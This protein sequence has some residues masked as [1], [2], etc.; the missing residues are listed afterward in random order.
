MEWTHAGHVALIDFGPEEPQRLR[1]NLTGE[2]AVLEGRWSLDF[3][4]PLA[5]LSPVPDDDEVEPRW[6]NSVLAR[7]VQ[8]PGD[9]ED[10]G[11]PFVWDRVASTT[12]LL[13]E[14]SQRVAV[15]AFVV[16]CD[17]GKLRCELY[18]HDRPKTDLVCGK[19]FTA[20]W[21]QSF[22]LGSEGGSKWASRN[23]DR[24][25]T[26]LGSVCQG[27]FQTDDPA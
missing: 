21:V 4:G 23:I 20:P 9:G 1:H 2:I 3:E 5:F 7:S 12:T 13:E 26:I 17:L 19:F 6:V 16:E 15:E 18:R 25:L 8:N 27:S 22:L 24:W 14:H 10:S 11:P